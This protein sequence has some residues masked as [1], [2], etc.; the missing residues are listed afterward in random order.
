[1]KIILFFKILFESLL[2]IIYFISGLIP[3]NNN[4]WIFGSYHNKYLDNSKY[5]FEY[6]VTNHPEIQ[7][8][9]LTS[10]GRLLR[11]LRVKGVIVFKKYSIKGF[12][13]SFRAGVVFLS[14]YRHDV[15]PYAIRNAFIVNA[16]HGVP[17]KT[18][19]YNIPAGYSN[20]FFR[21][22]RLFDKLS[23]L[24]PRFNMSYSLITASSPKVKS[25]FNKAFKIDNDKIAVTGDPRMDILFAD[26]T[27]RP[28]ECTLLYLPTF[29]SMSSIDY[30]SYDFQPEEW[31]KYLEENNLILK[32]KFHSN[33]KE[34]ECKYQTQFQSYDKIQFLSRDD[35]P[36]II[37]KSTKILL[38]D[39][40]L[41]RIYY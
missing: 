22:R 14:S 8:V 29:R 2:S 19:E 13:F 18:I 20:D 17:L 28:H 24:L 12:L 5:F 11:R 41:K 9:W 10:N 4:I 39:L 16:W 23:V 35:D 21:R 27:K 38:T 32:V 1:M 15:N 26:N 3:K 6:I 40:L 31:Q 37:L 36:Y 33:E 34:L 7:A 30:F 25:I